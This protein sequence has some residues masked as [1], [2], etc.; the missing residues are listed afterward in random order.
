MRRILIASIAAVIATVITAVPATAA[1]TIPYRTVTALECRI[2]GG[3][4]DYFGVC[5]GGAYD[6]YTVIG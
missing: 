1:P 6:G 4:N 3:V 5:V 2:G